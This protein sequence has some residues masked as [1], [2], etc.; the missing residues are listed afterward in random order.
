MEKIFKWLQLNESQIFI[1]C[2]FLLLS[3]AGFVFNTVA[4]LIVTGV[5]CLAIAF[6]SERRNE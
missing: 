3:I 4:G 5:E 2:G 1:I 6:L